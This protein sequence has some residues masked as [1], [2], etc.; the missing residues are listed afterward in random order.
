[1]AVDVEKI[2]MQ[3]VGDSTS[4]EEAIARIAAAFKVIG[5]ATEGVSEQVDQAAGSL[6][7]LASATAFQQIAAAGSALKQAFSGIADAGK[8]LIQSSFDIAAR[9]EVLA[10][11]MYATGKNAGYTKEQLDA[12]VSSTEKLG[13]TTSEARLSV[14]RFAQSQLDLSK[15][16]SLARASQD[17]AV[18]SGE[19]S[20]VAFGNLMN[21]VGSLEPQMLRQYGIVTTLDQA[22]G[23]LANSTD[24]VAKKNA[25]LDYILQQST[26]VAGVY[27]GAM[28]AIGKRMTS[29]PRLIEQAKAALG[30]T[31]MPIIAPFIDAFSNL[32]KWFEKLPAGGQKLV[33]MALAIGTGFATLM[34]VLGGVMAM[35]PTL[36]AGWGALSTAFSSGAI[37]T[38]IGAILPVLAP[39]VAAVGAIVVASALLAAAWS[40]NWGGMRTAV[41]SAWN[42]IAPIIAGLQALIEGWGARFAAQVQ[43]IWN[44]IVTILQPAFA[45]ISTW[46]SAIDWG[47]IFTRLSDAINTVG[48]LITAMLSTI[49]GLLSGQGMAAFAPLNDAFLNVITLI[50]LNWESTVGNALV[51]GYNLVISLANGIVSGAGAL[52]NAVIGIINSA[53]APFLAAFS[54]PKAGPLAQIAVW[55]KGVMDTFVRA[56]GLADFGVMNDVLSPIQD[57]LQAAVSAGNLDE[58][59]FVNLFSNVRTQVAALIADFRTTGNIS[60]EALGKIGATL[61]AG[62]EELTKYLRL[63]LQ[64]QKTQENLAGI[65]AEVAAAEK[66]GFV[67]AALKAKLDAAKKQNQDA[68]DAVDW[69]KQYLALQKQGVDMQLKLLQALNN[70]GKAMENLNKPVT[71]KTGKGGAA[72]APIAP[73]KPGAAVKPL[74]TSKSVQQLGLMSSEF[75]NMKAKVE[76]FLALPVADKI[77]EIGKAIL[78]FVGKPFKLDFESIQAGLASWATDWELLK[79]I[80]S[81]SW[82]NIQTAVNT[83]VVEI[84]DSITGFFVNLIKTWSDNWN[85]L[86]I[87]VANII[88]SIRDAIIGKLIEILAGIFVWFTG[89]ILQWGL[90]WFGIWMLVLQ[91]WERIKS[92]IT[93]KL[94]EI[95]MTVTGI[96]TNL[97]TWL[98]TAWATM[99]SDVAT[100][101]E[102]IRST[103]ETAVNAIYTVVMSIV[104]LVGT[105]LVDAFNAL[106]KFLKETAS[107]AFDWF[108]LNVL[109]PFEKAIGDISGGVLFLIGVIEDAIAALK[110]LAGGINASPAM[111]HSPSPFAISLRDIAAAAHTATAELARMNAGALAFTP[112]LSVGIAGGMAGAL[113][114]GAGGEGG[115]VIINGGLNFPNVRDGRDSVGIQ[116]ELTKT[117]TQAYMRKRA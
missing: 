31:F 97:Q 50:A 71:P 22:L 20:S 86:Q 116:R 73:I 95:W 32:L 75:V 60:E 8:N 13:I 27:E 44:S 106:G 96:I 42:T 28:G 49:Q 26:K 58:S 62:S 21:V 55:G 33:A 53:I 18:I 4:G 1:M 83:K 59:G 102:A 89:L 80:V 54:P 64:Y 101:W 78:D 37:A 76:A 91:W 2:I 43:G 45:Q 24:A 109:R 103:I 94:N 19:N 66:K 87:I 100:A 3:F 52:A 41:E 107:A 61:G 90:W 110:R 69:Q 30:T 39:I 46:I 40:G 93:T 108:R 92:E 47:A 63:S 38:A 35:L 68:K 51:W 23:P 81:Q 57:A 25:L 34:V 82:D 111:G 99:L 12:I 74:D 85:M 17:L 114:G 70:L 15:I 7:K 67:P 16:T 115:G 98:A 112:G 79:I 10:I 77:R 6:D 104:T 29:L 36:I 48:G 5:Q 72:V 56:F 117:V 65:E 84:S 113:A 14:T 11:S 105:T 9:N 88:G